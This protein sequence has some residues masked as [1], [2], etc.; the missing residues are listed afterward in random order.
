MKPSGHEV[1]ITGGAKGIGLALA[2]KFHAAGNAVTIVGRDQAALDAAAATLPG[3]KTIRADITTPDGRDA[4]AANAAATSVLVNNAGVQLS[5]EF[6]SFTEEQ[7][8]REV[9]T[10]LLA[11]MHLVHIFLPALQQRDEAAVINITSVLALVPK[12]SSPVYCATKAAF[13]SFTRAL[14]WQLEGTGVRVFEVLPPVVDT[15]MTAG[16][17]KGKIAPDVVADTVW[18]AYLADQPEILVGKARAAAMLLRLAPRL[19]EKIVRRT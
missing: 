12:E 14:R 17:G 2:K 3:L 8:D 15:A 18:P 7:I 9:E 5:G 4:I 13:R 1:L 19:A 6:A 11:P 10:N 16:R